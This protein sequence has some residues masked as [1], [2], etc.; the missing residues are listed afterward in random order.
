MRE[1]RVKVRCIIAK[2]VQVLVVRVQDATY[3]RKILEELAEIKCE[4][5]QKIVNF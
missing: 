1:V 5:V 3:V 4:L 2:N